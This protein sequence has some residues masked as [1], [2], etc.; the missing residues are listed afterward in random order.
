LI[1]KGD[2]LT[3]RLDSSKDSPYDPKKS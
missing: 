3:F 2:R 1:S